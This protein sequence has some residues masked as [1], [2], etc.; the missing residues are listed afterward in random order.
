MLVSKDRIWGNPMHLVPLFIRLLVIAAGVYAIHLGIELL[1][2]W[3]DQNAISVQMRLA[4]I[5]AMVFVYALAI[6][7]PFVPGVEIALSLFVLRGAEIAPYLYVATVIGLGVSFLIGHTVSDARL[8]R[9]LSGLGLV[10]LSGFVED[11]AKLSPEQRLARLRQTLPA[12]SAPL[13]VNS[14]YIVFGLLLNVPGNIVIGGGGGIAL[15]AGLSR[16]FRPIPTFLTLALAVLPVP[17][18]IWLMKPEG[19]GL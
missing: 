1:L 13:L 10:K 4:L 12:W 18:F 9:I 5:L 2:E 17:L 3:A 11:I 6:A 7:V 8:G 14:R 16:L 15:A 19:I